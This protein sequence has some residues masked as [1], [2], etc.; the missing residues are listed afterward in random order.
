MQ[1]P[2]RPLIVLEL[3]EFNRDLLAQCA[4]EFAL[5]S[6]QKILSFHETRTHT[7]DTTES[8]YLEPWVQWVTVH[9]KTPSSEHQIKH[10]GDISQ[11]RQTQIWEDL[12]RRGISTGVW[13]AI[14]GSRAGAENC[15]FFVPDPWVFSEQAFPSSL[16]YLI[17]LPRYL[18]KNRKNISLIRI[19]FHLLEFCKILLNPGV[20][21]AAIAESPRFFARVLKDGPREYVSFS[22]FEYLSSLEFIRCWKRDRPQVA[23]LFLNTVAHLQHYYW[24]LTDA[25]NR[26]RFRY[27]LRHLDSICERVLALDTDL[28]L[29]NGLSQMNTLHEPEWV[30]YRPA[31]HD[32]FLRFYGIRY[33]KVEPL[34]S[35]DAILL[36]DRD[37][38]AIEARRRLEEL[39]VRGRPLL[40]AETYQGDPKRLFYRLAFTDPAGDNDVIDGGGKSVPFFRVMTRITSRTGRHVQTG[41]LFS[42]LRIF[43]ESIENTEV[44]RLIENHYEQ[45]SNV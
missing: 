21:G 10:L 37:E 27:C 23:F 13:G 29:F 8:D 34:M 25:A 5:P 42:S 44:M 32:E 35:Y 19:G 16:N 14:N 39:R 12:S 22:L 28:V 6:L 31:D 2:T 30:A 3:N 43:P 1:Q 7:H 41:N 36:F 40:F 33:A 26:A 9:T 45:A 24:D 4:R 17:N 15:R 20:V 38:D 18:A 11:L